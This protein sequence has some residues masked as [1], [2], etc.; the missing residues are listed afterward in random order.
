LTLALN[1]TVALAS[2]LAVKEE[3]MEMIGAL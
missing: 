2:T 3:S 1:D